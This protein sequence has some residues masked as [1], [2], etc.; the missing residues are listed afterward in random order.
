MDL[1]VVSR[2]RNVQ[3]LMSLTRSWL[4]AG[5]VD[6]EGLGVAA[7]VGGGGEGLAVFARGCSVGAGN[8]RARHA[9]PVLRGGG[10]VRLD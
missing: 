1:G 9:S 2:M 4:D 8:M 6:G 3:W 5:E 7:E 10:K